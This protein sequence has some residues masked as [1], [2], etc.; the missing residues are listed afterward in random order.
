ML[1]V[2]TTTIPEGVCCSSMRM[3]GLSSSGWKVTQKY[4]N[5]LKTAWHLRDEKG[6][7]AFV[8]TQ[9]TDVEDESN[10]LLTYDRAITKPLIPFLAAANQGQFPPLPPGPVSPGPVPTSE[11]DPQTWSYTTRAPGDGWQKPDFDASAWKT[12]RA[13]FG[14]GYP[15]NTPWKDTPGDIWLRRAVTLPAPLPANLVVRTIHDEDVEVYVNGVLASSAPGYVG[16]YVDLPISDAAR[17]AMKP[18]ANL[19]AVH[20]HQ[21]IGG[22]VIDVGIVDAGI[23]K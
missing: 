8:Y 20:C 3:Q 11:G 4:Q 6:C 2:A 7:S 10:G 13:P 16:D 21:T 17:A 18:G 12:G 15:V 5:L 19:I 14:H 1:P 9:L 23:E 22:Q